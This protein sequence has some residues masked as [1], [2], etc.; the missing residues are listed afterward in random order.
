MRKPIRYSIL[1]AIAM[2]CLS[3]GRSW[4]EEANQQR[5]ADPKPGPLRLSEGIG[6]L[7]STGVPRKL[8]ED[9]VALWATCEGYG[10]DFPRFVIGREGTQS[11]EVR[12][13]DVSTGPRCGRFAGRTIVLYAF[14]RSQKGRLQSCG[15]R[16]ADLAHELGHVL[17][18]RDSPKTE[19]RTHAMAY[20]DSGNLY[21]RTVK[22]EECRAVA[23]RWVTPSEARPLRTSGPAL[24][25]S[26]GQVDAFPR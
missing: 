8:V 16:S 23:D 25:R 1:F 7:Y 20:L 3:P 14:A 9:A 5:C 15:S 10:T 18:L 4:A 24:A 13:V 26:T 2:V 19:C 12:F 11:V 22:P 6:I 17:G 21:Q